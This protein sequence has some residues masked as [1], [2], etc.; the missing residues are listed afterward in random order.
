MV[1]G[2]GDTVARVV[3]T[4]VKGAWPGRV[5]VGAGVLVA[6]MLATAGTAAA[7]PG[8]HE[9][10]VAGG[11]GEVAIRVLLLTATALVAGIGLF[12]PVS[13]P[14]S[15]ARRAL[16]WGGAGLAVVVA[17][18]AISRVDI[19]L[20][21][22]VVHLVLVLLVPALLV[23]PAAMA[24]AGAALAVLLCVEASGTHDGAARWVGV[25]HVAFAVL[26]LGSVAAV[27]T[28]TVDRTE[29]ARRLAPVTVGAGVLVAGTGVLQANLAGLGVDVRLVDTAF[30]LVLLGKAVL[31]LAVGAVGVLAVRR[32]VPRGAF[33]F[34]TAGLVAALGAGAALAAVPV[35]DPL[36]A[37]GV[38]LLANAFADEPVPVLVSPHRPGRNLINI[39]GA[40]PDRVAVGTDPTKLVPLR[41]VPGAAGGWAS[42][43]LPAGPATLLV[44][45]GGD[46]DE[47]RLDTGTGRAPA[48]AAGVDGPECASFALGGVVADRPAPVTSC[49]AE[50]LDP[51]DAESLR[52]ML[53]FLTGRGLGS[54]A[55]LTDGS[56]RSKVAE[57][58][59]RETVAAGGVPV[60]GVETGGADALIVLSGWAPASTELA[61]VGVRQQREPVFGHGVYLAPWLLNTPVITSV[62]SVI[63]PL[64]YNPHEQLP[65]TYASTVDARFPGGS[66]SAAGYRGWLAG[67]SA[68]ARK[69]GDGQPLLYTASLVSFLPKQ[70]QHHEGAGWLPNGTVVPVSGPLVAT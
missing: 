67:Q 5:L 25:G 27:A 69:L 29:L 49:P 3:D 31:L 60:V 18:P 23:R 30:G 42:V 54:V 52:G 11:A 8:H 61:K 40:D 21:V 39:G 38:P 59:V 15:G 33:R 63:L 66:P 37:P 51:G 22:L 7:A 10:A 28:S 46:T 32:R 35:P 62:A 44:R 65:A 43:D 55:L 13:G 70:F 53:G 41:A 26:W 45:R 14:A 24:A 1:A 58:L 36:P 56:A 64:R 50:R 34:A 9:D 4:R 47:V 16:V 12:A 2:T 68:Q 20:A 19:E 6:G 17:V 57:Q 48:V